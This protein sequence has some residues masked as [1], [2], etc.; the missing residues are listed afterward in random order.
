MAF[1]QPTR[2]RLN[3]FVGRARALLTEE[4]ARQLQSDY[5]IEPGTGRIDDVLRW[6]Q[7]AAGADESR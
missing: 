4:F 6:L 7:G 2:N 1:D 5:G 3:N